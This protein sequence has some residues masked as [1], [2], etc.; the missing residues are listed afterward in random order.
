MV[1][2]MFESLRIK[3]LITTMLL[4]TIFSIGLNEAYSAQYAVGD[5]Y[6]CNNKWYLVNG[7]SPYQTRYTCGMDAGF[8]E[9]DCNNYYVDEG[10]G[11]VYCGGNNVYGLEN[12]SVTITTPPPADP[13]EDEVEQA[14]NVCGQEDWKMD[15][16]TCKYI[17]EPSEVCQ[18]AY[19][20]LQINC[21]TDGVE[22]FDN[23]TCQGECNPTCAEVEGSIDEYYEQCF[24]SCG[25]NNGTETVK[26]QEIKDE[27][28]LCV[29]DVKTECKCKEEPGDCSSYRNRV[30]LECGGST[31]ITL[32]SCSEANFDQRYHRC[33]Q[34][35]QDDPP[36]EG[37]T[38]EVPE[39]STDPA[40]KPDDNTTPE[41]QEEKNEQ[42]LQSGAE[43]LDKI[44]D[45]LNDLNANG[46]IIANNTAKIEDSLDKIADE[47][48][49]NEITSK[50][51]DTGKFTAPSEQE[52]YESEEYSFGERTTEFLNQMKSTGVFSL[53][54]KI[55]QSFPSGGSSIYTVNMGQT[56]GGTHTLDLNYLANSL[57]A[58]KTILLLGFS[59]IGIRIIT[60]KR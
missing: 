7:V 38:P 37:K 43:N 33:Y 34:P 44:V 32:Y 31:F 55:A 30:L 4:L 21:S 17:C 20:A 16:D 13:C 47:L 11:T 59:F 8:N 19:L 6:Q 57:Y 27:D 2:N 28:G 22:S 40:E 9:P 50:T 15:L 58:L 10:G 5:K 53:P 26:Y 36:E 3:I 25:G 41:E 29:V 54:S 49:K 51:E 45:Q 1:N 52:K 60:L 35:P 39:E 46:E 14:N 24:E 48:K 56:F 23:T 18:S 42:N 12:Y